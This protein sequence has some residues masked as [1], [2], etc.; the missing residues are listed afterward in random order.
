[1]GFFDTLLRGAVG[2]ATGGPV[3]AGLGL[4]SS[5]AGGGGSPAP[6]RAAASAATTSPLQDV[7]Q[8]EA[9]LQGF[10]QVMG[11]GGGGAAPQNFDVLVLIGGQLPQAEVRIV[12]L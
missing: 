9:W 10:Q 5:V 2:F 1:M 7:L 8:K 12:P 4:L 6:A 3:G 11:G